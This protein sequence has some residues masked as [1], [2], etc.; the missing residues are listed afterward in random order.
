MHDIA[1]GSRRNNTPCFERDP[2]LRSISSLYLFASSEDRF[3]KIK[4]WLSDIRAR[5]QLIL[6]TIPL[7]V[8]LRLSPRGSRQSYCGV[9]N[10]LS[11]IIYN[12]R[13]SKNYHTVVKQCVAAVSIY[14]P[15]YIDDNFLY[16]YLI[17]SRFATHRSTPSAIWHISIWLRVWVWSRGRMYK[18]KRIRVR[19]ANCIFERYY[20]RNRPMQFPLIG[21]LCMC[22][23][24]R[25]RCGF[26]RDSLHKF[27]SRLR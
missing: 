16:H 13:W 20:I 21:C 17:P 3:Y 14:L 1:L 7:Y 26:C 19:V 27:L 25:S 9:I 8:H 15:R 6:F 4:S 11:A 12:G 22:K 10:R 18:F 24:F 2:L 5:F 23:R